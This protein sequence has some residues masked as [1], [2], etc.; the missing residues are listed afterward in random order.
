MSSPFINEYV[1]PSSYSKSGLSNDTYYWQVA[2]YNSIDVKKWTGIWAFVVN[3]VQ[4]GSVS[5]GV[6]N[7]SNNNPIGGATVR[8]KQG[9]STKY[10]TTS[11]SNGTYTISNVTPGTYTLIG[12]KSGYH[13]KSYSVTVGNGENL[14]GK[15]LAL[16][17]VVPEPEVPTL[18]SPSNWQE[19]SSGNVNFNWTDAANAVKYRIKV[20]RNLNMSSP[21]INEYVTYS[22]YSKS[23][24]SNDTYYWQ[25]AAYNSNNVEKWTGVW[26]FNVNVVQDGSVS[27]GVRDASNNNPIGGA[28]VRLKQGSTTKYETTSA[29]NGTYTIS[30]VT[31]GT[32]TLQATKSGY[33]TWSQTKTINAG[34]NLT[35]QNIAMIKNQQITVDWPDGGQ[36][37]TKGN[38]YEIRWSFKNISEN[39]KV[40]LYKGINLQKRLTDNYPISEKK[41]EFTPSFDL[42]SSTD[43]KIRITTIS[44]NVSGESNRTFTITGAAEPNITLDY[45]N[46]DAMFEQGHYKVKTVVVSNSGTANLSV[47]NI[48]AEVDNGPTWIGNFNPPSFSISPG[49]SK[50]FKFNINAVNLPLG[51]YTGRVKIN[52]NDPDEPIKLIE[53]NLEVVAPMVLDSPQNGTSIYN[54]PEFTWIKNTDAQYYELLLAKDINF[55]NIKWS[56]SNISKN[57]TSIN[58]NGSYLLEDGITYFWKMRF[59]RPNGTWS[60]WSETWHFTKNSSSNLLPA[61]TLNLPANNSD[62]NLPEMFSWKKLNGADRYIM[63]ISSNS[64]FT[65]VISE[66][67]AYTEHLTV[68]DGIRD[69]INGNSYWWRIFGIDGSGNKGNP[70]NIFKFTKVQSVSPPSKP[71]LTSPTGGIPVTTANVE[72]RWGMSNRATNC[73]LIWSIQPDF[74]ATGNLT[75][76]VHNITKTNHTVTLSNA[77]VTV[78]WKIIAKNNGGA[79]SS[80]IGTFIYQNSS[81]PSVTSITI[82]SPVIDNIEYAQGSDLY[83]EAK[84]TGTYIGSISGYWMVDGQQFES[85]SAFMQSG[86]QLTIQSKKLPTSQL[87]EHS[88]WVKLTSPNSLESNHRK[89][90]VVAPQFGEPVAIRLWTDDPGPFEANG[91]TQVLLKAG[92]IDDNGNIVETD[93]GRIIGFRLIQGSGSFSLPI[94]TTNGISTNLFTVG[95]ES[96]NIVIEAYSEGLRTGSIILLTYIDNYYKYFNLANQYASDL[97]A[98]G[99]DITS[100][101]DYFSKEKKSP[102]A[103]ESLRRLALAF[104][105][106]K[107][108]YYKETNEPSDGNNAAVLGAKTLLEDFSVNAGSVLALGV[109]YMLTI[110]ETVKKFVESFGSEWLNKQVEKCLKKA[111]DFFTEFISTMMQ[112]I[113]SAKIR[114]SLILFVYD[115]RNLLHTEI[116][117]IF[118]NKSYGLSILESI[119]ERVSNDFLFETKC[120]PYYITE[121]T[122][123]YLELAVT[124]ARTHSYKGNYNS[125]LSQVELVLSGIRSITEITHQEILINEAQTRVLPRLQ[126]LMG[127]NE[128]LPK[129]KFLDFLKNGIK[130]LLDFLNFDKWYYSIKSC[131]QCYYTAVYLSDDIALGVD[132]AFGHTISANLN[133]DLQ[134]KKD[135]NLSIKNSKF[136]KEIEEMITLKISNADNNYENLCREII[137]NLHQNELENI[138]SYFY[139]LSEAN[140]LLDQSLDL[141]WCSIISTIRSGEKY[142]DNFST[143][144]DSAFL[145]ICESE[146]YRRKFIISL[147]QILAEDSTSLNIEDAIEKGNLSLYYNEKVVEKIEN[148]NT[149]IFML[150]SF[151]VIKAISL[152]DSTYYDSSQKIQITANIVNAGAGIAKNIYAKVK[153]T[154]RM[155]PVE[156]DSIY[157]GELKSGESKEISIEFEFKSIF[158]QDVTSNFI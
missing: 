60:Y 45:N 108:S 99:Y 8:L 142:I 138:G 31:P 105:L 56:V 3:V 121:W 139:T 123:H 10:E 152:D 92:V 94:T 85:I 132:Y 51:T 13:D 111:T 58:Y 100:A 89:Y 47:Q 122:Q 76:Y 109:T 46:L 40:H 37:L 68:P 117:I 66:M 2:A 5:G 27:G 128:E 36:T 136:K 103:T 141:N 143:L 149:K 95:N 97:S 29:S 22:S 70:S 14:T 59:R 79:T 150:E 96:G 72:F 69:I 42:P 25:V 86:T 19:L 107:N 24:L 145:S 148:I 34:Q 137:D 129:M 54:N 81:I 32:Y 135:L 110:G 106:I 98:I 18:Q 4:N 78:Y 67:T 61:T 82:T 65:N 155:T 87:G 144:I 57:Q 41:I 156:S 38:K 131:G 64:N 7:A 11:A 147:A 28:T 17:P 30:N 33:Q 16:E 126:S 146:N 50:E 21:F 127:F 83:A 62:V 118:T 23:G 9:S 53:I 26:A 101:L 115:V 153:G 104:R 140:E 154:E 157:I 1:T 77:N 48:Q 130:I 12:S 120:K 133:N 124:Y 93:N 63:E 151:P 116:E 75:W 114:D 44:E 73:Q 102:E 158:S 55:N 39:I 80:N 112:F 43:Y 113:P 15:N 71:D 91:T 134:S 74:P 6:R 35:G 52:S 20:S 84:F 125:A 88:V 119:I 49:N 90:R